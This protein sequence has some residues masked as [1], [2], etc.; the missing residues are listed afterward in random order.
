MDED[1]L[2]SIDQK[3]ETVIKLLALQVAKGR[4]FLEQIEL[5]DKSGMSPQDIADSLGKTPNNV[6]VQLHTIRKKKSKEKGDSDE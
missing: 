3:L 5:L 6:R 1:I 4:T 2:K